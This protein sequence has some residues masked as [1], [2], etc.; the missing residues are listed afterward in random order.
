M[1]GRFPGARNVAQFWGNLDAG[2]ESMRFFT[3]EELLA[4]GESPELLRDPAYVRA[5]PVLE[6]IELFDAG[7]FGHSPRDAAIMDPQHRVFLEC[8]W[9]A[10][11][12]AGYVAEGFQGPIGVFA[13]GG[14]N[15]Y[16]MYHLVTNRGGHGARVG[17]WLVRHTGNDMNFLATRVSYKLNL[18]GPEHQ[19]AD[20]LLLLA[21]GHPPGLPEPAQ[22][23]VRHGA[24][25]RRRPSRCRRTAATSTR[26][27]RSSRRTG[28]AAPSTPSSRGHRVRQRRG[29]AWCSSG[30]SDARRRRRPHPRRAS[31]ARPSTTT[32]RSR[33]ATSRPAW[34]GRRAVIAEA[35]AVAG[36]DAETISLH[37]GARHR[38]ADRRP[39]RGGGADPGLPRRSTDD[40]AASAPSAR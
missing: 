21:R 25:R 37:R 34:R 27:G 38:H 19:R 13:A 15:T 35:L 28:T 10:L 9:E 18:R 14:M 32:A 8:A 20:G 26:R 17:E 16:M 3:D 33:S 7:F 29:R 11:E 4:A 22:R 6:D 23:R 31:A 24:G 1:A 40:D 12:H 5:W 2:V 30:S 39:D 36:V